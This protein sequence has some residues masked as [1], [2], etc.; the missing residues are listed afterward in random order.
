[1]VRERDLSLSHEE[2][3]AHSCAILCALDG[4]DKCERTKFVMPHVV[5]LFPSWIMSEN[6]SQFIVW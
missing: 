4:V 1:M 6:R 2:K 5:I 3:P